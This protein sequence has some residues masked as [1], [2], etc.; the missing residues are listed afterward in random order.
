MCSRGTWGL[1]QPLRLPLWLPGRR[2]LGTAQ[3][4]DQ[5]SQA[6]FWGLFRPGPAHPPHSL[7]I[8]SPASPCHFLSYLRPTMHCDP[9]V[10]LAVF[11]SCCYLAYS[12][13]S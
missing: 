11:N 10:S 6:S 5:Q 7:L 9:S 8:P 4:T 3:L 2:P 13:A 1:V 12:N